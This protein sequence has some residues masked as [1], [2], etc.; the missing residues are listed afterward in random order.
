MDD[1]RYLIECKQSTRNYAQSLFRLPFWEQR[2]LWKKHS[3]KFWYIIGDSS[4]S[5]FELNRRKLKINDTV[6]TGRT[7][8]FVDMQIYHV[9]QQES[10][11]H[12]LKFAA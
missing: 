5:L 9:F 6:L 4:W 1:F 11:Y 12:F 2:I 3:H 8:G 7:T 10:V